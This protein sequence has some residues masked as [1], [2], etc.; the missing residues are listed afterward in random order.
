M[1]RLANGRAC[2]RAKGRGVGGSADQ[3]ISERGGGLPTAL[4]LSDCLSVKGALMF[5]IHMLGD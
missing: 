1:W 5:H 2:E 3:N 4:F